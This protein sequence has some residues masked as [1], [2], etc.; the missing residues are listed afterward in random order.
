[1][2]TMDHAMGS[3]S[4]NIANVN[5]TGYK[6]KSTEF[7]TVMSESHSSPGTSQNSPTT[8]T[9]TTGLDIFGVRAVDRYLITKQGVITPTNSW[10]D[11]GINGRGFFVVTAPDTT[12]NPQSTVSE[13]DSQGTLYT[14]EGNFQQR[15]IG[16]KS[17]FTTA[18]GQ[19][20]M[21]WMADAQGK[22]PG[23]VTTASSPVT[24]SSSTSSSSG[25]GGSLV[26]IYTEPG[27]LITGV[28]TTAM[29]AIMNLPADAS[30]TASPQSFTD[31]SSVTDG[32]GAAQDLTMTWTRVD[33]DNWSVDFSLPTNPASGS[34][35]TITGS[36]V[37]VTMD[38][39]GNLTAPATSASGTGFADLAIAW[40]AGATTTTTPSIDLNSNK[41]TITDVPITLTVYD[42][43]YNPQNL[44]LG[45][46]HTTSGTWYMRVKNES[47]TG[48]M[49]TLTA[50]DGST[51]QSIPIT[52]S[53]TGQ[54]LSPKTITLGY[55]W[56]PSVTAT[57]PAAVTIPTVLQ[58]YA[59]ALETA[60]QGVTKP[61]MPATAA[62]LATYQT[63]LDT[64]IGAVAIAAPATAADLTTYSTALYD[65]FDTANTATQTA[66][67]A[68]ATAAG[69]NTVAL[70]VSK[71]TQ[72]VG[73]KPTAIDIRTIEQDGYESG[74]LDG[75]EFIKTGELIGHF[76]NGRTRT[77]A[78]VPVATFTAA[79]QLDPISGTMFRRTQQAGDMSIGA[80]GEQ[81][82]GAQISSSAVE[83]SNVDLADEFSRMIITQKA[84]SMNAT[85][86]KTADEMTT[87]ARDLI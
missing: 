35:G 69:T 22:I 68:A 71:L 79:D 65:A 85:V 39:F 16:T 46:E 36:P 72:Y 32:T 51:G 49:T 42:N 11:L 44:T 54:I 43:A 19:F 3:I 73:S 50:D 17:Y 14:R 81:G 1:M 82:S 13:T 27:Q 48:S 77:L 4:Q 60:V 53:G 47:A 70:D 25:G 2:Q 55:A 38:R 57:E 15:A 23:Q 56:T 62:Q 21:G 75:M 7:K 86:F 30:S 84:Y 52:F 5:T 9:A 29:Q 67:T 66:R 8:A 45:F 26:P 63:A 64:A 31:S 40:S 74:V 20:L 59:T 87:S 12:G 33:G 34:V 61:S 6:R 76:S 78:M 24:S 18:S 83:T 10:S 41:P 80:I 37:T 28:A 58:P